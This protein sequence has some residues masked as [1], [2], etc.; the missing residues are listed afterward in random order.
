MVTT[1]VALRPIRVPAV[2]EEHS[3]TESPAFIWEGPS[4][5]E[6][7]ATSHC[8]WKDII[9]LKLIGHGPPLVELEP[10]HHGR[11]L[12]WPDLGWVL[13]LTLSLN[14]TYSRQ[15]DFFFFL[16]MKRVSEFLLG[17]EDRVLLIKK[18]IKKELPPPST[19]EGPWEELKASLSWSLLPIT[20]TS[21]V[22]QLYLWFFENDLYCGFFLSF[23]GQSVKPKNGADLN[24]VW[25]W[26]VFLW[27]AES[28]SHLPLYLACS[29]SAQSISLLL[30]TSAQH[31]LQPWTC[32]IPWPSSAF[33]V[34]HFS[35][36]VTEQT[37]FL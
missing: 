24:M 25:G 33:P 9:C 22:N 19:K 2:G 4:P 23:T 17:R 18:V 26:N 21:M 28:V 10:R 37:N 15:T 12:W 3:L 27:C 13:S 5:A 32:K 35:S 8:Q 14:Y 16:R 34:C 31:I 36:L 30:P 20:W 6:A 29:M 11:L 1:E 7:Q